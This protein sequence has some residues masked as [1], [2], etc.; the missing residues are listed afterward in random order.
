MSRKFDI[1][2]CSNGMAF[3]GCHAMIQPIT[4][5]R[6]DKIHK[7]GNPAARPERKSFTSKHL[8]RLLLPPHL[9]RLQE[10]RQ[11]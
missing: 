8:G 2:L 9:L 1:I 6:T 3:A 5:A 4:S 11:R 7:I 10:N